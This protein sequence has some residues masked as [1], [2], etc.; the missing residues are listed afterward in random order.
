MKIEYNGVE[1]EMVEIQ[2]YNREAVYSP[3]GSDLLYVKHTIGALCTYGPGGAPTAVSVAGRGALTPQQRAQLDGVLPQ[4][5]PTPGSPAYVKGSPPSP[6]AA[7]TLHTTTGPVQPGV[8][9]YMTDKA[10]YARLMTPRRKLRLKLWAPDKTTPDIW[11]ESPRLLTWQTLTTAP[12]SV[13]YPDAS[14]LPQYQPFNNEPLTDA[15]NGPLPLAANIIEPSGEAGVFGVFFQISTCVVPTEPEAEQ[16][17]LSHRWETTHG[18]DDNY[19]LTRTI[20][21]QVVFNGGLLRAAQVNPDWLR[22]QFIHPIPL[23]FQ[24]SLPELTE[25]SD[26]LGIQY[27]IVDTNP[28]VVFDPG[29]SGATQ[30]SIV[31]TVNYLQPNA[32]LPNRE[33]VLGGLSAPRYDQR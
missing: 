4:N 20:R 31:E 23:G 32:W 9:A 16:A 28:T 12:G 33:T 19:Y 15:A 1:M 21:G 24:R 5:H 11:L 27:T 29:S 17:V 22:N 26:R 3:D 18:H 25:T 10:L 14:T 2:A 13:V 6:G 30:M 8:A 7:K